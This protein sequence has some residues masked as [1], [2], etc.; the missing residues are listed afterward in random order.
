MSQMRLWSCKLAASLD[1]R[2]PDVVVGDEDGD[3]G[4]M[5]SWRLVEK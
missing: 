4:D 1:D 5:F 2:I 3:E